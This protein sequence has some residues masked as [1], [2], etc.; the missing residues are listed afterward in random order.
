MSWFYD[1]SQENGLLNAEMDTL[2]YGHESNKEV[3]GEENDDD[4]DLQRR[5]QVKYIVC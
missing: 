4:G 3:D 5:P 2:I 1:Q